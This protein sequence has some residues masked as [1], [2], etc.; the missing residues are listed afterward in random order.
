MAT[1]AATALWG[2][3]LGSSLFEAHQQTVGSA[4]RHPFENSSR[5]EKNLPNITHQHTYESKTSMKI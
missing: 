2:F 5:E 1:T 4:D 3:L